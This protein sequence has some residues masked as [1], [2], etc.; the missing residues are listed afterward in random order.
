L[1]R[2]RDD[3]L[4]TAIPLRAEVESLRSDRDELVKLRS[5]IEILRRRKRSLED[6]LAGRP[7]SPEDA[8]ASAD[9]YQR[10]HDS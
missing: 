1:R 4:A 3:L 6:V 8:K 2:E 5:E 9:P 7:R 10:F